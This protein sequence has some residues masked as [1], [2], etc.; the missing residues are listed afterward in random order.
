LKF[1]RGRIIL[2]DVGAVIVREENHKVVYK[3]K[4]RYDIISAGLRLGTFQK[5][6]LD[7]DSFKFLKPRNFG[8]RTKLT[9]HV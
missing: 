2:E 4:V 6:L 9:S 1:S 3:L 7:I 8:N 5:N